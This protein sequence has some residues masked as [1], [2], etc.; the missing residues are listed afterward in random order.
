MYIFVLMIVVIG[1]ALCE[2][3]YSRKRKHHSQRILAH[4]YDEAKLTHR[5]SLNQCSEAINKLTIS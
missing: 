3:F 2:R 5:Q 1:L 4:F